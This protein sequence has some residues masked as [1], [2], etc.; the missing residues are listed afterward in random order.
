MQW[1]EESINQ[2]KWLPPGQLWA[3][4]DTERLAGKVAADCNHAFLSQWHM[5][6]AQGIWNS[7]SS[8]ETSW[9]EK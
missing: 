8:T 7:P 9:S 4:M 1:L 2:D 3:L 6:S 5:P